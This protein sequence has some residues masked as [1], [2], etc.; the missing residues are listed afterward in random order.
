MTSLQT[1]ILDGGIPSLMTTSNRMMSFAQYDIS[2]RFL[3][4]PNKRLQVPLINSI[5]DDD[6]NLKTTVC[7]RPFVEKIFTSVDNTHAPYPVRRIPTLAGSGA[8]RPNRA[9]LGPN[10]MTGNPDLAVLRPQN[11]HPTHVTPLIDTL[12]LGLFREHLQVVGPPPKRL[13]S[14]EV[15]LRQMKIHEHIGVLLTRWLEGQPQFEFLLADQL[16][17]KYWKRVKIRGEDFRVGCLQTKS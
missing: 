6:A 7:S 12:A 5:L 16:D 8:A 11:Q 2:F 1:S 17:G 15:K 9:L 13:N 10:I 3:D 14:H 4:L